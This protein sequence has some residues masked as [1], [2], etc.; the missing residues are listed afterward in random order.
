MGWEWG[1][2]KEDFHPPSPGSGI[3]RNIRSELVP[4]TNKLHGAPMG[5]NDQNSN[6]SCWDRGSQQNVKQEVDRVIFMGFKI[7]QDDDG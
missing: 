5:V 4:G 1:R 2:W 6:K 3:D 7:V